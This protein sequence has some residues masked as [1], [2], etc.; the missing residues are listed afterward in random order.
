MPH[1]PSIVIPSDD[2]AASRRRVGREV[3]RL[4][5]AMTD[6]IISGRF[7]AGA[8]LSEPELARRFGVSRGP[9]REAIRRLEERGLVRRTPNA[10]ARVVDFT[11]EE[12][13]EAFDLREAIESMAARLAAERMSDEEI[14]QLRRV[15]TD[16]QTRGHSERYDN[17]FHMTIVRGAKN[18]RFCRLLDENFYQL[19]QLWRRQRYFWPRLEPEPHLDQTQN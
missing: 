6:E 2:V 8:K 18:S 17:D 11:P 9:L 3:E 7:S 15:F 4:F 10:G 5:A 13:L 1:G 12:I 16:E 14:A 19:F